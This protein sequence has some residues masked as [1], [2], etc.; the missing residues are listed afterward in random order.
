[1]L[2][3][4]IIIIVVLAIIFLIRGFRPANQSLEQKHVTKT[5]NPVILLIIDSLMAEPLQNAIKEGRAPALKY[6]TDQ[7]HYYPNIIS[8]YPTMSVTIDSSLLTGTYSD[9]H[10]I[11]G[12]VWYDE[13]EKRLV[14]YGSAKEEVLKLGIKHVIEDSFYHL[15]HSHL[16]RDVKTIHEILAIKG[17]ES[18]SINALVYRGNEKQQLKLSKLL[19]KLDMMPE[20]LQI[21]TP[22]LFSYGALAQFS[23]VNNQNTQLWERYGFNDKFTAQELKYLIQN[24][25]L[26][27]FTIAYFPDLDKNVHEKG[28]MNH[29]DS[30]EKTDK[31]IQEVLN[32]YESWEEALQ[33]A[34]WIVMGDSGQANVGQDKTNSFIHLNEMLE[35]HYKIY[36][37]AE[38]VKGDDQIVIGHN[39]RMAFIY[40]LDPNIKLEEIASH[41]QQDD[42]MNWIAWKSGPNVHVAA[43][44]H[45]EKLT[46]RPNGDFKDQYGQSWLVNGDYSI[47]DLSLTNHQIE[48]GTYPDALARL[49]SSL[50]SHSGN[51][52]VVD[53]KPGFEFAGDGTPVHPGGAAHGSMHKQDS[54]IPM[55]VT[56][57]ETKP[58]HL[59]I[60]DLY[61]WIMK[62]AKKGE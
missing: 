38:P 49:H 40:N 10:R 7:G 16:S 2:Y 8:S 3:V 45:K 42:R 4:L 29:I 60:V 35:S 27:A 52:L 12:L 25:K 37:I 24:G 13:K 22:A 14:N 6:L 58:K 20:S 32:A 41:L 44:G 9:K 62:L 55:I 57:T 31:Q 47:L 46:F 15:N 59:R 36:N 33:S 50:H 11:P 34:I 1:M 51:Y 39:E 26:P 48:Y 30:I 23:P 18:A 54:L 53:A 19:S 28:P 61:P 43:S 56:G 5:E 17:L 21:E